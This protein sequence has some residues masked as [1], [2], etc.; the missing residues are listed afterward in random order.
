MARQSQETKDALLRRDVDQVIADFRQLAND[1]AKK[2]EKYYVV[3][4]TKT[5]FEAFLKDRYGLMEKIFYGF[6][7]LILVAVAQQIISV[8]L[9]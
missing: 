1:A 7:A 3:F 5:D 6:L 2:D 8:A 4:L 9:R